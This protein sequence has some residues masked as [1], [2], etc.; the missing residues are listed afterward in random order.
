MNTAKKYQ[1]PCFSAKKEGH[2]FSNPSGSTFK[3]LTFNRL[4]VSTA[5]SLPKI[6][7]EFS[8][9]YFSK[10]LNYKKAK[11]YDADGD[12]KKQWYVYY[13]FKN[14]EGKYQR[15]KVFEDINSEPTK[16]GRYD[17]ANYYKN[18][19][20]LWLEEGN[21]PFE[22]SDTPNENQNIISCIDRFLEFIA[23]GKLRHN[24]KRKYK[25]ELTVF[26]D[27]V[28][29]AGVNHLKIG[30]IKKQHIFDFIEAIKKRNIKSGKTVNHYLNDLRRFFNHYIDNYDDYLERNPAAKITRDPV[31]EK[32]NI[33]YTEA[34][35]KSI[36]EWCLSHDPYLWLVCQVIYYTGL[37]NEAELLQMRIGDFDIK[38]KLFFVEAWI[39]KSNIRQ[40]AP[41]YPEFSE[42]LESL[43]LSEY[44]T[45][46]Y[47]FGRGDKPGP[48]RVGVDNFARR[49]RPLKKELGF[50]DEYGLYALKSTRACHLFDDG[51]PI[52]DIQTLFRHADPMITMKYL[53]SLGRVER[54]RILDKGRR[55]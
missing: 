6:G 1:K 50:G 30:E 17:L 46:Y 33:A 18:V 15:F 26:K 24:T 10:M 51:A 52:R 8:Q 25:I 37:R 7:R 31:Q 29:K 22:K 5:N 55:I 3:P 16:A 44:P 34:E 21:S 13:S 43:N 19:I 11:V 12:I 2:D 45:D 39:S 54:G 32:G 27:W 38:N 23:N 20:N 49:F 14:S 40:S 36:K 47:L 35:F 4:A 9:S 41:I 48:V 53:K 28:L 42:L